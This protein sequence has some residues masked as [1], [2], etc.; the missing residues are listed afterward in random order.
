MRRRITAVIAVV[1]LVV[2]LSGCRLRTVL[3]S[4]S[5]PRQGNAFEVGVSHV[6]ALP[7]GGFVALEC[8]MDDFPSGHGVMIV[9][10]GQPVVRHRICASEATALATGPDGAIYLA[11]NIPGQ[12]A[13]DD[14][15]P[16]FGVA[17][18]DPVTGARTPVF[19]VPVSFGE[20][21]R[22]VG[23]IDVAPDGTVHVGVRTS[24]ANGWTI[25]RI[26]PG[27][28][29]RVVLGTD[30]MG[31][32]PFVV[33]AGGDII[34]SVGNQ[35]VKVDTGFGGRTVVAGAG[36]AG[37]AGDG[38][39]A[40]AALLSMPLG[41]DLTARGDVLI[42]D[43]GNSRVRQVDVH[44]GAIS[45]VAGGGDGSGGLATDAELLYPVDIA[46]ASRN[47][48][49]FIAEQISSW[50]GRDIGGQVIQLGG[51]DRCPFP[52]G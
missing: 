23:E 33:D 26:R 2:T 31:Q 20:Q 41:V 19:A 44:T 14:G 17:R 12:W 36:A 22:T 4:E 45:T 52:P 3:S 50:D 40:P 43:A 49:S 46:V 10:P 30:G 5:L 18:I 25:Q 32:R 39:P 11:E 51:D 48:C 1:L 29:P 27:G 28:V 21:S 13:D 42:V 37:F 9:R 38:G 6:G 47:G 7:D 16:F 24:G 15:G 34:T 8:W 35:V